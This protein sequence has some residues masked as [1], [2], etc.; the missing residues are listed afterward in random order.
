[1]KH[2]AIGLFLLPIICF[3]FLLPMQASAAPRFTL[4]PK[5]S[6]SWRMDTNYYGAEENEREVY[7]Y[8]VQAGFELGVNTPKSSLGLDYTLNSNY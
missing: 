6:T 7:T 5:V 4:K 3:M 1:M 8:L 2:K